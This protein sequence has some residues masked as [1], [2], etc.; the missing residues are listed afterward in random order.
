MALW[1]HWRMR[2]VK[3]PVPANFCA[4]M[5]G[6][7]LLDE[8][9]LHLHPVWQT[10]VLADVRRL[11][12][13]LHFIVTTHNPMT[14]V[15]ARPGEVRRLTGVADT[16]ALL[17]EE[18]PQDPRLKTGGE[19]YE[20]FFGIDRLYPTELGEAMR[21]Y[22]YLAGDPDRTEDEEARLQEIIGMFQRDRVDP[23]WEPVT[24]SVGGESA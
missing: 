18:P 13:R 15:G 10:H 1:I 11:F 3:Q 24:R 14:L 22:S 5:S 12:P 8:V 17:V 7:V 9:D 2:V 4:V 19:L 21:E 20:N 6:Y 16:G 23:G